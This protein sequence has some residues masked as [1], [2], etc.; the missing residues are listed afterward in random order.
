MDWRNRLRDCPTS[1]G[2][3]TVNSQGRQPLGS[4]RADPNPAQKPRRGVRNPGHFVTSV[5]PTGLF[6]ENGVATTDPRGW[7][8]WLFT[9]AP[10]G[11][12]G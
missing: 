11:L 7:R 4:R 10:P 3:A 6:D 1:P 8:P 9:D 5:A 12:M 2:G